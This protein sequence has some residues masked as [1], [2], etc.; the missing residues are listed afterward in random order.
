MAALV[1]TLLLLVRS[2]ALRA[3][4]AQIPTTMVAT[5]TATTMGA[6]TTTT[7]ARDT[8]TTRL[9][10]VVVVAVEVAAANKCHS[11]D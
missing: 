7:R 3:N 2:F 4:V 5:T 1:L 11:W 9:L 6:R 8:P 10:R